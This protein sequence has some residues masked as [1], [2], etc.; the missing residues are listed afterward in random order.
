MATTPEGRVKTAIKKELDKRGFWRAGGPRPS[1]VNG[2]YYMPVPNG[3]GVHGIPDFCCVWRGRALCIEAKA[4]GGKPTE[5][6]LKRHME[7]R[8]AG[9]TVLLIDDV[10][11]L[12]AFF[13]DTDSASSE[14]A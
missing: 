8:A 9:G 4:P 13:E 14:K 1:V 5:N 10:A 2:W 6:Q 3:M 11:Q 12:V 7:I